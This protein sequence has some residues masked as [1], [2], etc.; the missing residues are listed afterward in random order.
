MRYGQSMRRIRRL[1]FGIPIIYLIAI[2][3]SLPAMATQ[4]VDR[5]PGENKS[6]VMAEVTDV[7][8]DTLTAEDRMGNV[9]LFTA[10]SPETLKEFNVGDTVR[11][12]VEMEHT[13]SIQKSIE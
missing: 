5:T 12:T 3:M 2:L 8:G 1:L 9:Y 11:L 7:E 10:A 13:T 4:Q 6:G